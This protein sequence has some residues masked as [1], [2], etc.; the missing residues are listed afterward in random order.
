MRRGLWFL[1]GTAAGVYS[2]VRARRTAESLSTD[3]IHDRLHGWV[4]G[5]RVLRDEVATG[6]AA[7]ETDLRARLTLVPDENDN[8][9]DTPE[10]TTGKV[11]D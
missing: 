10:I 11:D 2:T 1:A 7:K 5:A 4:A 6:K 9:G 8:P 3:G